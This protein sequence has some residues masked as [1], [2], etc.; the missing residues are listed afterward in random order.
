MC[1]LLAGVRP[2]QAQVRDNVW[3]GAVIGGLI[4]D[5]AGVLFTHAVR[6]SDLTAGQYAY[7][8]AVFGGIGAGVGMGIDVM[9]FRSQPRRPERPARV[10]IAP[11]VWKN[12][13]AVAV[14]WRW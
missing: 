2:A 9:L 10:L 12:T 5:A 11:A 13:K 8:A 4:G 7:G 1:M 6:D 3:N 14:K